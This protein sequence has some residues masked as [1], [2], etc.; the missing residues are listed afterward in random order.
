MTGAPGQR[1][2]QEDPGFVPAALLKADLFGRVERGHSSGQG[3]VLLLVRR[4]T[5]QA[6]WW[7]GWLGRRLARRE[8][9][10]LRHL[11]GVPGV[12]KLVLWERGVLL[13]SWVE[14]LPMQLS[15][16]RDPAYFRRAQRLLRQLHRRRLSHNDLAKEPNWL[17]GPDGRPALVD[18]QLARISRRRGVWFRMLAREDLRHLLKHKRTYCP[19]RLTPRERSILASPSWPARL[20]MRSGKRVYLLVTRGLLGWSDRE[21]AG[22][23]GG[24]PGP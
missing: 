5:R 24:P 7:I 18:F 17:V 6:R 21:G 22:D 9:R 2:F 15:R 16:P 1:G 12:P 13:R 14:G 3:P 19:E 10:A 20:W 23:R 8:A 11:E 4:D